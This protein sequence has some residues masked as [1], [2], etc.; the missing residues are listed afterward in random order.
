MTRPPHGMFAD[1]TRE[2]GFE[3]LRVEGALPDGLRGTLFRCGPARRTCQGH[4]Y[5]HLFDGDV[6]LDIGRVGTKT[7]VQDFARGSEIA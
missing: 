5:K 2:H 3:P 1:L 4:P 6:D 7:L